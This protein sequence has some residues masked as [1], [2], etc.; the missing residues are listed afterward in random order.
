[1]QVYL[2]PCSQL[3]C[4]YSTISEHTFCSAQVAD[5]V[6]PAHSHIV[7]QCTLYL[8]YQDVV[9]HRVVVSAPSMS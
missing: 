1:M 5:G 9:L 6:L 2:S 3:A 8:D 7:P 4:S